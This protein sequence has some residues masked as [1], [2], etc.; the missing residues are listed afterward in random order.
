[1]QKKRH[2]QIKGHIQ[3]ILLQV[4]LFRGKLHLDSTLILFQ[5][6]ILFYLLVT[7]NAN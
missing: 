3:I 4:V 2:L 5:N 7:K 6:Y 1:M